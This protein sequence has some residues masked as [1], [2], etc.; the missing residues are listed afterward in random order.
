MCSL[1]AFKIMFSVMFVKR[2]FSFLNE[3]KF[4]ENTLNICLQITFFSNVLLDVALRF[5]RI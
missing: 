5:S 2:F 4:F 3:T 1:L